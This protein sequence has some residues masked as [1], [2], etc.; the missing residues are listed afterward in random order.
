MWNPVD[1]IKKQIA[2]RN[3]HKWIREAAEYE[4]SLRKI[5]EHVE[6]ISKR[7]PE[8][9]VH[10]V[11]LGKAMKLPKLSE[12]M[13]KLEQ[14][15]TTSVWVYAAVNVIAE[16]GGSVPLVLKNEEGEEVEHDL[17][18]MRPNPIMSWSEIRNLLFIWL[19]TTGNA[20]LWNEPGTDNFWALRPSRMRVVVGNDNRSIIG[21]AYFKGGKTMQDNT[22][23]N[24]AKDADKAT[25]EDWLLDEGPLFPLT[26]KKFNE[27]SARYWARAERGESVGVEK[28]GLGA[29]D[30][31]HPMEA[32][33]VI[34][35]KYA[36][37][38]HDAYGLPPIAPLVSNLIMDMYAREWNKKF[39]ENG[40]IPPGILI[41][42][43]LM[44]QQDF[45]SVKQRFYD[46]YSGM[47]N[48]GKPLV[49]LGGSEGASYTTFPGQHKD[50]E[51]LNLLTWTRDETLAV[52]GVPHH[53]VMAYLQMG[54]YSGSRSTGKREERRLFWKDTLDPKL[55]MIAEKIN[56]HFDN[57]PADRAQKPEGTK[58][59]HDTSGIEDLQPDYQSQVITASKAISSGMSI[60]EVR[61]NILNL[62]EEPEDIEYS[63]LLVP[64]NLVELGQVGQRSTQ[65]MLPPAPNEEEFGT[66]LRKSVERDKLWNDIITKQFEPIEEELKAWLSEW[67][68]GQVERIIEVV[69]TQLAK[70]YPAKTV[71]DAQVALQ[72]MQLSETNDLSDEGIEKYRA[73][74]IAAGEGGLEGAGLSPDLFNAL[75]PEVEAFVAQKTTHLSKT[76]NQTTFGNLQAEFAEAIAE[77]D[78][79]DLITARVAKVL[80]PLPTKRAALIARTETTGIVNGGQRLAYRQ[81]PEIV[82]QIE[83][84]S[85]RDNRV[86]PSHQAA[87]GQKITT[88]QTFTV[89]GSSL[90]FPGDP[91]GAVKEIANCRCAILPVIS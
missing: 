48:S 87:D 11:E 41:I 52:L 69:N 36:S 23:I 76:I 6:E 20:Y 33:D 72:Q 78:T 50:L 86:R 8:S 18:P 13:E 16:K 14:R 32:T 5:R 15:Y 62:P 12:S 64:G 60:R 47:E 51:F 81:V 25:E 44:G 56:D 49:L 24:P 38:S 67:L 9:M 57:L 77:G 73:W 43:H 29:S 30:Q 79:T 45:E 22:T 28:L 83:W 39:F 75:L 65:P 58:F 53:M 89:G 26:E 37:P 66:I 84:L 91:Q 27:E 17:L 63:K 35:F 80:D 71:M 61:T 74:I 3:R 85:S 54:E 10:R 46:E 31:W 82:E 42:P 88:D 34:H 4:Q 59:E 19:E 2:N 55:K 7:A 1:Q 70:V 40:A 68:E 21:Y 90:R